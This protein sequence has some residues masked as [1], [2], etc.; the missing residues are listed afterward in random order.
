MPP[1]F[2]RNT[3]LGFVSGVAVALTGFIGNAIAAR[4]LG[5]DGMGVVAYA[6]WCVTVATTIA[7]LGFGLVLQRYIPNLRAEGKHDEAEGLIGMTARISMVASVVGSVLLLG[8]LYLPGRSAIETPSEASQMVVIGLV[9]AW[10]LCW[11]MADIYLNYLKGEQ[12][13]SEFASVS[14]VSALIKLIVMGFG[15]WLFGVAGALAAYVGSYL[16]PAFRSWP[17]LRKKG[18]VSHGLRRQIVS[19]ALGSWSTGVIGGLVFGRT[20]IVFLEHYADISAVGIFAAAA[21]L[22][23]TAMQL[24]PLLLS[25]LLP[26]F[27][28]QH[29]L[30]ANEY[31]R[32][33]YRTISSLIALIAVP[34]CVGMAAI[35]PVL[36]PL[37]FGS[38]FHHAVPVASVLL[39]TGAVTSLGVTTVYLIYS[40]GKVGFLLISNALGLAATIALGFLVIPHFGLMGA[41]WSRA[42]V[43][44]SM[45]ALEAWYVTRRLGFAPPY[46]ALG[47]ISLAAFLQGAVAYVLITRL[48]G[49]LSLAIA[50][51]TA[52]LVYFVALRVLCVLPMVDPGLIDK[53]IAH[54][55][56][57][58]GR[59]L[60]WALTLL[61]PAT[62][63][64]SASD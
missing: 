48:G 56:H 7:G 51:P 55:P 59:F 12:R 14:T 9:L 17:L 24:T 45:V 22:T 62:Q 19:F 8:W 52:V 63:K 29:G 28:Q 18:G 30:G 13:F 32:R 58:V 37:L 64:R 23:D 26:Y 15:A 10:F 61:S 31:M 44:V 42:L 47:M 11:R 38:E 54:A 49:L 20:E 60:A 57:R 21:T 36:V 41:A 3:A 1:T 4:L 25:A 34:L 39:I 46:R 2:A 27:S 53:L 35:A 5:P 16:V 43:Q 50:V 33:L 6:V 40:T